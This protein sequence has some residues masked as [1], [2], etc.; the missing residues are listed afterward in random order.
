MKS[1]RLPLFLSWLFASA[2]LATPGTLVGASA[3][4]GY[5]ETQVKAA[6]ITHLFN[7]VNW[8]QETEGYVVCAEAM[9]PLVTTVAELVAAKPDLGLTLRVLPLPEMNQTLCHAAILEPPVSPSELMAPAV[10][11]GILTISDAQGFAQQG[12]MIELERRP[13][14]IGLIVN[15][16]V[17]QQAGFQMSSKLLRLATIVDGEGL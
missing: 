14:R 11:V 2:L 1:T 17:A 7:F 12:G 15:L 9:T 16:K 13:S 10:K 8:P 6:F 3:V 4:P 5:S